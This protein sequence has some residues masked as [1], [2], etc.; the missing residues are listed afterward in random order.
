MSG[1]KSSLRV[2]LLASGAVAIASAPAHAAGFLIYDLSAEAL[3]KASAVTASVNEPAAVWFNPAALA[4][5]DHGVSVAAT[6]VAA[7]S[8]FEVAESSRFYT[9]NPPTP[10][11]QSKPGRFVLPAVFGHARIHDRVALGFGIFP[12]FGLSLDWPR[13]WLGRDYAIHASI[14]TGTFNP[15]VAVQI[16]EHL[17]LAA[18]FAATRGSV[19]FE[20][21]IPAP[22]GGSAIIGGATWGFGGNVALLY[23][24][25]PERLHAAITY[26]SRTKLDFD[27]RVDFDPPPEFARSLPDEAGTASIT[28]PDIISAGIMWRP[29]PSVTLTFDPNLVLWSTFDRLVID[30]ATAP[31]K[32]MERNNHN[33]VTLRFGVDWAMPTPGLSVRTGFIFDQNPSPKDT[34]APSLP[35]A[36]RI[37]FALGVGYRRGAFQA[38]IGYLFVY[39]LPSKAEGGME[40]EGPEGTYHSIAQL[41]GLTLTARFGR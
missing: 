16:S 14:K 11:I 12:A 25:L 17:S 6:G 29:T 40:R 28:L 1:I 4:F 20:N 24:P 18:G 33:A 26:R 21:G 41:L 39:F 10:D 2:A 7:R 38:D 34:L 3:G 22:V 32:I 31:D 5:L 9:A 37:D 19:E 8:R 15:T 23:R 30:F 27:G 35:D 13:D 36:N